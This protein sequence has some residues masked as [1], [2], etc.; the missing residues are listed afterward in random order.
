MG[1]A[2]E[3]RRERPGQV[4]RAARVRS[5]LTLAELG[6]RTGYSAAQVSRYERGV[7]PMTDVAVLRRFARAL[8]IDPG[9]LGLAAAPSRVAAVSAVPW[10]P[11]SSTVGGEPGGRDDEVRRRQLL[12]ALGA[13]AA[14]AAG[15]RVPAAVA[16]AVPGDT[17]VGELLVSQ[18][19]D[20]MLG[21][22]PV[23]SKASA[24]AVRAGLDGALA[25]FRG[26]RY[27]RLSVSLPRLIAAA[28]SGA[29][30]RLPRA[31]ALGAGPRGSRR[32][33]GAGERIR[34]RFRRCARQGAGMS[35]KPPELGGAVIR[36]HP[37][38]AFLRAF[39]SRCA[40]GLH[41]MQAVLA[42]RNRRATM[43]RTERR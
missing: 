13:A 23:P 12:A 14:G 18:V 40:R 35:W 2:L 27:G 26:S 31:A 15:A 4:V 32:A 11:G 34:R 33:A 17:R 16:P 24:D 20:A 8:A 5:G 7:T 1:R 30:G 37:L 22:A 9:E 25:D 41:A 29:A 6:G 21:L 42:V 39:L 36:S 28:S 19:R 3:P 10:R 43:R 38:P